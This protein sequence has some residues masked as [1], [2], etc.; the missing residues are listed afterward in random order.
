MHTQATLLWK[1]TEN[2]CA[3]KSEQTPKETIYKTNQNV[4]CNITAAKQTS[5]TKKKYYNE[6]VK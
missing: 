4:V 3:A 5:L 6:L 2:I 1:T